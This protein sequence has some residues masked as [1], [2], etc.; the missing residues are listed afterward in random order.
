MGSMKGLIIIAPHLPYAVNID[1]I[2]NIDNIAEHF[3]QQDIDIGNYGF[4]PLLWLKMYLG[5]K[6]IVCATFNVCLICRA[7]IK[8]RVCLSFMSRRK[9][10]GFYL[11]E[12]TSEISASAIK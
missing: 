10:S 11:R 9:Q 5:E 2:V 6:S 7:S 1:G 12:G 3:L 4:I 8:L